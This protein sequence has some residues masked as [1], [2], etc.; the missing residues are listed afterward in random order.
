MTLPT[1][2]ETQ[3]SILYSYALGVLAQLGSRG[4][5]VAPDPAPLT[6]DEVE[7]VFELVRNH[8][9]YRKQSLTTV[10]SDGYRV[11]MADGVIRRE[12]ALTYV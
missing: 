2:A 3:Q 6:A 1:E 7:A 5:W 4:V 12:R 8:H 10:T 11:M 9:R